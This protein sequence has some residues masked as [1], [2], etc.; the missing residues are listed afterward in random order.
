MLHCGLGDGL[1]SPF[2][3]PGSCLKT[4]TTFTREVR[5]G[6]PAPAP[7]LEF[8]VDADGL[9]YYESILS[10]PVGRPR[11]D[12]LLGGI[13]YWTAHDNPARGGA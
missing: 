2:V 8:L 4:D 12:D 6:A 11:L 13:K 5:T 10:M 9:V 1:R 7:A 3:V